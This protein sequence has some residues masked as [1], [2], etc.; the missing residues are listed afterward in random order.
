M[1]RKFYLSRLWPNW[2]AAAAVM[3]GVSA[4]FLGRG[5]GLR[6]FHAGVTDGEGLGAEHAVFFLIC[7]VGLGL[8]GWQKPY[9]RLRAFLQVVL[10]ALALLA[11]AEVVVTGIVSADNPGLFA[12]RISLSMAFA[13]T[14][15]AVALVLLLKPQVS[16]REFTLVQCGAVVP[17]LVA[18]AAIIDILMH[19]VRP[20]MLAHHVPIEP[21]AAIALM[22]LASAIFSACSQADTFAG[23]I[24]TGTVAARIT[25]RLF[26]AGVLLPPAFAL[27]E[28]FA[29][30]AGLSV[31]FSREISIWLQIAVLCVLAGFV[32][33]VIHRS[34]LLRDKAEQ[35]RTDALQQ[36]ERQAAMLE[37]E[38]AR[39]T[40]ELSR[41]LIFNQRLAYVASRTTNGVVIANPAGEI[42]WVNEGFT[43]ITGFSFEDAVGHKPGQ[44]LQG[45]RTDPPTIRMMGARLAA[46]MGFATELIN[47]RRDGQQ[48]WAAIEVQPLGNPGGE[49]IGF[50]GIETDITQRKLAEERIHATKNE[51][52]QLNVQLEQAIAHAQQSATEANLASQAKS[53]FLA[54]MSHE[55]R[56]PLNGII[57]MSSLLKDTAL[58]EQ[59]IDF[60]RTIEVSGESLLS[61][62]NDILDYTKIE[63]GRIEL[64]ASP[65]DLRQCLEDTLELFTVKAAEKNLELIC[66]I[67]ST[68][69]NAVVG[70]VTRLRQVLINLVGNA[71]KF[72][73]AGEV[74]LSLVSALVGGKQ[75]LQC[76][77][78]DS[79]IGIPA[80]RMS[81]LFQPFSQVDSST[82]RKYGGTGLGLAISRRLAEVMGGGM[83]VE[84]ELGRGSK[85]HFTV[86]MPEEPLPEPPAWQTSPQILA[87]RRVLVAVPNP[88][89]R[90]FL[91]LSLAQWGAVA[92]SV[93]SVAEALALGAPARAWDV[94]LVDRKFGAQEGWVGAAEIGQLPVAR[95]STLVQVGFPCG[96]AVDPAFAAQISKPVKMAG[97]FEVLR[98]IFTHDTGLAR[99]P[100]PNGATGSVPVEPSG[101]CLLLVEDNLV[102]QRVALMLLRK[103]G[104]QPR[105]AVNGAEALAAFAQ[106]PADVVLMDMEMPVLDGCEATRRIRAN[107]ALVQPWIVALTANAMHAD[108][109]R[110]LA[111]GMNDF[112]TKPIR[113]GDLT[114]AFERAQAGIAT[115]RGEHLA[116]AAAPVVCE[117]VDP[118][119]GE[120]ARQ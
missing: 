59:Q 40:G 99:S 109:M 117:Y 18:L 113:A 69:P 81:R 88:P 77:V 42:E 68:V 5:Q 1:A 111:S 31:E 104:Y 90:E 78:R 52:E 14:G 28:H 114:A 98:K 47:Y 94:I 91:S 3:L 107:S 101:L 73:A 22:V 46:G 16:S 80:D 8:V 49:M 27:G 87:G 38:V 20:A 93:D 39:R 74:E 118:L 106:E 29:S 92:S 83:W 4:L 53:S 84:S 30:R 26:L 64:E 43:R 50:M 34:E 112:V 95:D 66:R 23:F 19:R 2:V 103:L 56:T 35:Q 32:G 82:T 61:I 115:Y 62:I 76:T 9:P 17:A 119:A 75:G 97:L 44:L 13:Q 71:L 37:T 116:A 41:A 15:G 120:L 54:T 110:A 6:A 102:N 11:V 85:F 10:S 79:G 57:G 108:R 24:Q 33:W 96:A 58:D 25:R 45:P 86:V 100:A 105:L 21:L 55:I 65:F 36:V 72:T 89:L 51:A 48:Y 63:S 60:V 70:D 12:W 67:A 7:G